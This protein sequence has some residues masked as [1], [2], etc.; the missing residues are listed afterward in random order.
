[1]TS[2]R[3][4]ET[5]ITGE[6]LRERVSEL[7]AE[8][9]REY[10]DSNVL[11]LG[12]L[13][14]AIYFMADLTRELDIPFE[15]DFMAVSSYGSSTTSSGVVRIL[16]DLDTPI[17]GR[18]VLVI[19]DIVDS[20]LTLSYL[21][22]NLASRGPESLEVCALLAKP[23]RGHDQLVRYVGFEIPDVFVVGYG[24]DLAEAW[25]GLPYIAR[26]EKTPSDDGL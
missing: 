4:G 20:G 6:D 24:L 19:E 7:A 15:L 23:G 13:K 12:V 8:I 10:G 17:A 5:L 16:K 18:R 26:L 22:K 9:S 25:R 1:M 2:Y 21:L 11:V 3:V 14:G